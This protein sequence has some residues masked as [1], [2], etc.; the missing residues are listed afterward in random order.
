MLGTSD[1]CSLLGTRDESYYIDKTTLLEVFFKCGRSRVLLTA[2][3]RFGKTVMMKAFF[4]LQV[5]TEDY[6]TPSEETFQIKVKETANYKR[7][8]EHQL[9][10]TRN[11]DL[12]NKHFEKYP[13]LHI[14]FKCDLPIESFS[15]AVAFCSGILSEAFKSHN[16]LI[17]EEA[18]SQWDKNIYAKWL[19]DD[20]DERRAK[21]GKSI[22]DGLKTL[23]RYVFE[24]F[25]KKV[26]LLIDEYDS[27][28]MQAILNIKAKD[29]LATVIQFCLGIIQATV[30]ENIGENWV[31]YAFIT[32]IS[33]IAGIGLSGSNVKPFRF[34]ENHSFVPYYGLTT[35]EIRNLLRRTYQFDDQR[36]AE[37]EKK[38]NGY[39]TVR[40]VKIYNIWSVLEYA[41]KTNSDDF[42]YEW[43]DT[44]YIVGLKE[45][46]RFPEIMKIFQTKLLLDCPIEIKTVKCLTLEDVLD[47]VNIIGG[48]D[49]QNVDYARPELLFSFIL[50]QGYL[51]FVKKKPGLLVIPNDQIKKQIKDKLTDFTIQIFDGDTTYIDKCKEFLLK[52][53]KMNCDY[54]DFK[55]FHVNL[56]VV[57]QKYAA[58]WSK[59]NEAN[60]R[61]IIKILVDNLRFKDC[62][63]LL[64]DFESLRVEVKIRG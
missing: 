55:E 23:V 6:K 57:H 10:I 38:F 64:F 59:K 2:P 53:F 13:T 39:C 63:E 28:I 50:E 1:F 40:G 56:E 7:F 51:S 41:S 18:L 32:G 19:N 11:P 22:S 26:V 46:F 31:E 47:L 60:I 15:N 3:R 61:C 21:D 62:A 36:I 8:E 20:W 54:D 34:L 48:T 9:E 17:S 16:Y 4:E 44:G 14:S 27:V 42:T 33:H 5:L 43:Q 25:N 45:A 58:G 30:K 29:E 49:P 35:R 52:I 37:A 24:N 12:M